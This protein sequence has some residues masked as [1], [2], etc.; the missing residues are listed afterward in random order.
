MNDIE[1]EELKKKYEEETNKRK[2]INYLKTIKERGITNNT[3]VRVYIYGDTYSFS[4]KDFDIN[5][6]LC[7]VV[8]NEIDKIIEELEKED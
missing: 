5:Y 7:K 8:F 1:Y 6:R 3:H 2:T 4:N